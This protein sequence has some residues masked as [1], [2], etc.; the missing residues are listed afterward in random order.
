MTTDMTIVMVITTN[1]PQSTNKRGAW[2]YIMENKILEVTSALIKELNQHNQTVIDSSFEATLRY[3]AKKK[4][5]ENA[6]K[7]LSRVI[8][9]L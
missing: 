7:H 8:E 2:D 9:F 5:L 4:H 1:T 3:E 6:I